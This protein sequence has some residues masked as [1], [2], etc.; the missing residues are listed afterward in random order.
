MMTNK[1]FRIDSDVIEA[2]V[3]ASYAERCSQGEIIARAVK[4]YLTPTPAPHS[5]PVEE[6]EIQ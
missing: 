1:T 6:Q 3:D 5:E 2:I 4:V